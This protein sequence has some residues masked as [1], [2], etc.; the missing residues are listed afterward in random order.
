MNNTVIYSAIQK[1]M[2]KDKK[3]NPGYPDHI[4]AAS[5]MVSR[6][7]GRLNDTAIDFKYHLE[8]S[9]LIAEVQKER[10]FEDGVKAAVAAIRFLQNLK[11]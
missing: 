7:A 1:Q 11:P 9:E 6:A 3:E 10:L 2:K 5:A 4:V 8:S